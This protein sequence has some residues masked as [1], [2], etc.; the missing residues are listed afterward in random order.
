MNFKIGDEIEENGKPK[1]NKG[2]KLGIIIVII[3]ALFCGI[4]VFLISNAFFGK[5]EVKEEPEVS[6]PLS[7]TDENV[8]ILYN[9]VT[10]GTN[11][12]RNDKFI[13]ESN[14]N[15]SSF[16][17]KERF[18]YA[19]QFAQVEDFTPT[20][21]KDSQGRKIYNIS[22]SKIKEYMQRFFGGAVTY[23]NNIVITY[24]F[25]FRINGQNVGIMTYSETT[26]GFDTVFD[27]LEEKEESDKIIEP[28]YAELTAAF[29]EPDGSYR[30]EEKIVYADAQKNG[31]IYT[32]FIYKDYAHTS[33]IETRPNQTE[34]MI[35]QNP[36]DIKY[37]KEKAST[38]TYIFKTNN[39][40][41]YFDN[42]T[43]KQK[44]D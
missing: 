32:V 29:K 39:S 35:R 3:I 33:L 43:I 27:G 21:K 5:K 15:L 40:V 14:V 37:Y 1:E 18:Y 36:I 16:E 44:G 25:S 19:L 7:L 28:Y 13:T 10:Y 30:L 6:S 38:I 9:Y 23:Y 26:D 31:D 42:S 11:G 8:Q 20:D 34:E 24:P 12:K 4:T 22:S 2:H 17:N 41:L